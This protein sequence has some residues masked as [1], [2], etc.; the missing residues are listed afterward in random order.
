MRRPGPRVMVM[1]WVE[2][3]PLR[4]ILDAE[5]KLSAEEGFA[6]RDTHLRCA[7]STFTGTAWFTA[8]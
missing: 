3:R 6:D 1:E 4:K 5:K 2:G 7:R 8:I